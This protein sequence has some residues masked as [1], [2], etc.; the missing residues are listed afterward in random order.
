MR[1]VSLLTIGL[2]LV[3]A[4]AFGQAAREFNWL[5]S[6]TIDVGNLES[7][8][9]SNY[10][11]VGDIIQADLAYR[12]GVRPDARG[13]RTTEETFTITIARWRAGA[14]MGALVIRRRIDTGAEPVELTILIDGEEKGKWLHDKLDGDRRF[15]DVFFVIPASAMPR[16][17]DNPDVLRDPISVRIKSDKPYDSFG[18]TFYITRDWD[19]LPENYGGRIPS[20][21]PSTGEFLPLAGY[22]FGLGREGD[23][24]WDEAI[25]HYRTAE[26]A[27]DSE[28][29][30]CIRRKIR[31]CEYAKAASAVKDTP[32]KRDFD[33]HYALGQYCASNGF[34]YEA[35]DEYTKA[36]EANPASGDATYNLAEAMEYCYLPI[37]E[38]APLMG[39]AGALYKRSDVNEITTLAAINMYEVPTSATER[40]KAPLS[41][42]YMDALYRDWNYVEQIIY[43]TSR[44]AWRMRTSFI[45]YTEKDPAWIM[46]LGWLWGPPNEAIPKWGMYDHTVSFA[47]YGASHCGGIDCG[48]AWSGC[49]NVGPTRSWEVMIHEWNHQFDWTCGAAEVGP[50]YPTTHD[51]DGCGKQPIV[52]M[53]CGHRSAMRYYLTPAQYKRIEPSDPDMP[54]THIRTWA[55]YG[56]LDAPALE[57]T[58]GEELL[59]ELLKKKL[60][61]KDDV[62]WIRGQADQKKTDLA[63]E[64]KAWYWASR[65]MNLVKATDNEAAFGPKVEPRK[66]RKVTDNDHNGQVDLAS[67]FPNAAPKAYAYAHT[68]IW[69]PKDQEVRVWYGHHDALRVWHNQRMVH[70]GLYYTVAY[71]EDPKWVDMLGG[72]LF[73]QEG[74]NSLLVKV[75]R[76]AG[77]GGYGL[78]SE[79][80][81]S[82]SVNLVDFD[83]KP[84]PE[85]KYQTETPDGAVAVYVPPEV[86]KLYR[87]DD[88]KEDYIE[89]LPRLT[90][91]DFRK[92]TGIAELTLVNNV[93]L[94]AIPE[95]AVQ[96]G[97]NVIT[98][99]AIKK[100]IAG[101]ESDGEPATPINFLEL[102]IPGT[103]EG[104]QP[105][106]FNAFKTALYGDVTLNNFLNLDREG[107]AA[108]RY[109]ENGQPRDLLLIRPE[110]FEEYLSLVDD[111]K[112][113][114]PGRTRDRILGYWFIRNAAYPSTGNRTWRAV[115]V[116]KTYLGD[117]YPI[118]EQDIL[119]VP[120]PPAT[121]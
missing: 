51:S 95:S 32:E 84:L 100:A 12:D 59:A 79:K 62:N 94:A 98:L 82:F 114:M 81:W 4:P 1:L 34:W 97:T 5:P 6:G 103:P 76:C 74:W 57:G 115:I 71:Y 58:T 36:V 101:V 105:T 23:H 28:L 93:Y 107:A 113:G 106:P 88:V 46:H 3:A 92:L 35:L 52:D 87:W 38:W 91:D 78:S 20:Q 8:N 31:L 27:A 48:P 55:V 2:C 108:L 65:Q 39:R 75:E 16:N 69:S 29:A 104:Q 120:Q 121:E 61:T 99:E 56:P 22:V 72:H 68:Y 54:Q 17:R 53:G 15:A 26:K 110:Y 7:E 64:A 33:V 90:Q 30:R 96:K 14:S 42:E 40:A 9:G 63:D 116:A 86:G 21:V 49:C 44:G 43:G 25:E 50:G 118:D 66:W 24:A 19:L 70:E 77:K 47:Q 117:Q 67:L 80:D 73:L 112:S 11:S 89:M 10:R 37:A 45:P 111:A 83:N 41:K 85:L 109:V 13:R 18:Y 102:P 119:A 60:A